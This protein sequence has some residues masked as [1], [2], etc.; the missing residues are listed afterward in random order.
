M[1]RAGTRLPDSPEVI[2]ATPDLEPILAGLLD[3]YAREFTQFHPVEFSEDGTFVYRDL[4]GYWRDA[5][6]F[7]FLIR[8]GKAVAGFALVKRVDSHCGEEA[9]WDVAEF[10]VAMEFRRR[11][12]GTRSAIKIWNRFRG[13]WQVRVLEANQPAL[14]FW[15][16]TM[17]EFTGRPAVSIAC[18]ADGEAW[19]RFSFRSG[20][21]QD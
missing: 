15:E 19:R 3:V 8:I 12:V 17:R 5:G 10:F 13:R 6:K 11:S 16:N 9:V 18:E 14:R 7:P 1:T 20:A 2:L 21:G 4:P